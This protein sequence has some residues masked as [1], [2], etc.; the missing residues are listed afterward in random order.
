MA[1]NVASTMYPATRR[2]SQAEHNVRATGTPLSG[3]IVRFSVGPRN[4]NAMHVTP[5]SDPGLAAA[6]RK[7]EEKPVAVAAFTSAM[8]WA[9]P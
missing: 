8:V 5:T 1:L 3:F 6:Y 2:V 4:P 9:G 7:G